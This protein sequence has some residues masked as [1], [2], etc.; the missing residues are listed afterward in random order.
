MA[1]VICR[2]QKDGTVTTEVQ[3]MKGEGCHAITAAFQQA[4]GS[5]VEEEN[6]PEYY[7]VVDDME[8][9]VYETEE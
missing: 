5:T 2:I 3:G 1:R 8:T 7:D 6:R 9:K 4:L